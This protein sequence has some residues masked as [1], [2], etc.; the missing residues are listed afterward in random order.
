MSCGRNSLR[1]NG[2][3]LDEDNVEDDVI[4]DGDRHA[5]GVVDIRL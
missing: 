1:R 3:G 4:A 5:V 2:R